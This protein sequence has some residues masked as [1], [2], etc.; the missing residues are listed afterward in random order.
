MSVAFIWTTT[1]QPISKLIR[2][3]MAEPVSHFATVKFNT[4]GS[5]VV[6]HQAFS[7]FDID[8]FPTW[9]RNNNIVFALTPAIPLT[10]KEWVDIRIPL[11]ENYA[12][13]DYD[14]S[15]IYYFAYRALLRKFFKIPLPAENLWEDNK[16]PLCTGIA[17]LLHQIHPE[18]FSDSPVD[19][20]MVSP[21][22]LY[23]MMLGSGM[24]VPW[25]EGNKL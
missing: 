5:G 17:T 14:Y 8:W 10:K 19:F 7:G 16:E 18:W 9:R 20:D 13:S 4:N 22:M 23:E 12:G 24:F 3:G 21:Y 6:L 25:D 1:S 11:M 15:A 2:W